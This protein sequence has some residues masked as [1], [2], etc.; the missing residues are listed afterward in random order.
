MSNSVPSNEALGQPAERP[1]TSC[2]GPEGGCTAHGGALSRA[3]AGSRVHRHGAARLRRRGL[4]ARDAPAR[5]A[6]EGAVL[7]RGARLHLDRVRAD[8]R[9]DGLHGRQG[10]GLPHQPGGDVRARR[11]EALPLERGARLLERAGCR[12]RSPARSRSGRRSAAGSS[13][14]ATASASSTSTTTST[15]W[16]SAMFVEALGTA[17]L[18]F[19][20]LGIVDTR[21]PEGL[22]RA[23]DRPRRSSRSSSP[24]ARS[25]TRRSTRPARSAR[26]SSRDLNGSFHNWTRAAPRLHPGQL[27]GA[28]LAASP[29]TGSRRPGSSSARSRRP[30]PSPTAPTR[31][32]PRPRLGRSED[33]QHDV[34]TV[35]KFINNPD[36]VVKESLAGPRPRRTPIS[37]TRRPREPDRRPQGRARQRQGRRS[38]RAA[39]PG[40]SRCTAASSASACSTPPVR[41]RSSPRRCPTRCSLRRRPSTAAPASC[42]SSRTT[43]ATS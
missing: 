20:I 22:G 8:R 16:G 40:T 10:L 26:S 9:R 30:S 19:T 12:R 25:R 42:T 41:A 23:R 39:A 32:S 27:V 38:S 24:S 29:T 14:S 31:T 43:R 11:H 3:E 5:R 4:G 33:E 36:D 37:L 15:S 35:K 1:A 17:I 13:T 18:L 21:S 28:A 34:A 2:S 7:G 6:D